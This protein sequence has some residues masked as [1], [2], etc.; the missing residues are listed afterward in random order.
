MVRKTMKAAA[1]PSPNLFAAF[2][3]LFLVGLGAFLFLSFCTAD[4]SLD[5]AETA[6]ACATG[7]A[8]VWAAYGVI[9]TLGRFS[10]YVLTILTIAWGV[11]VIKRNTFFSTWPKVLGGIIMLVALTIGLECLTGDKNTNVAASGLIAHTLVPPASLYFGRG[12]LF[13][14]TCGALIFGA[15]ITFGEAVFWVGQRLGEKVCKAG[16]IAAAFLA[17]LGSHAIIY[18]RP[19]LAS[20]WVSSG[21]RALVLAPQGARGSNM[22]VEDM[23]SELAGMRA[24]VEENT[25]EIRAAV[26]EE[27][28]PPPEPIPESALDAEF[29]PDGTGDGSSVSVRTPPRRPR[30]TAAA[31]RLTAASGGGDYQLPPLNL[32]EYAEPVAGEQ[33]GKLER[34]ARILEQTL[35]EFKIAGKVVQIDCGPCVTLFEMTL[36]PGIRLSKV[37]SLADNI[38][39][40]LKAPN[41]RIIAPIPGKDSIGIE[42]PNIEKELVTLREVLESID[43]T[44]RKELLPIC[45]A[46]D[47]SGTPLMADLTKMPHVLIAGATGSGKSVCINSIIMSFLMCC[48]PDEVKMIMFDPKVVELS[49]FKNVPHLISPVITDMKRAVEVLDWACQKMDERYEHLFMA[50]VNNIAKFNALGADEIE[51]RLRDTYGE[52]ELDTFPRHLPYIVIFIDELADLMMVAGK[53]VEMSITRLAAKSRAVGIHLILATQR[54]S[55]DVITGLIKANMPTRIAFQVASKVDSRTILDQNGAETLL[56]AGDMLYLPPGVGKVER[57]QGV[58]VSDEEMARVVEFARAQMAPD[59]HADLDGPVIGDG[60][61]LDNEEVDELFAAAGMA[62]LESGRGSVSLL[63]R[64]LGIGYGRASRIIDQLAASGVLGPFREGKA[65]EILLTVEEFKA[66]FGSGAEAGESTLAG[67]REDEREPENPF[68]DAEIE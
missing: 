64:K 55:V 14:I 11:L 56:G 67:L 66:R 25:V 16:K 65:R 28:S 50:G 32:L 68:I 13:I 8:G 27:P 48:K 12:G 45:L 38:A 47:V 22:T 23:R 39:M 1:K 52:E 63:Q 31:E 19:K 57:A 41:V 62:I 9:L 24:F 54:P 20:L 18:A 3:G 2:S 33:T 10:A 29:K 60:A 51:N 37:I 4:I 59:F 42:I 40:A 17:T 44:R 46:K 5:P 6:N 58:F 36:A 53:E 26:I 34:R 49:R 30:Q 7:Y 15:I 61:K 43:R 35:Q 21:C